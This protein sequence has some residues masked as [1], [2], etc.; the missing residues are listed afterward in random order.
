MGLPLNPLRAVLGVLTLLAAS[1]ALMVAPA[2]ADGPGLPRTYVPRIIDSPNPLPGGSFGWG[3]ASADLT[4]D[5]KLDLLVA[6][7]E[8]GKGN[9]GP[10]QVFIYNGVTGALVD[11]INPPEQNPDSAT[12][13]TLGFVYVETMPDLGSCPGGDGADADRICDAATIGAVDGIPEIVVGAR[14]LRVDV[15]N[16]ADGPEVGDPRLGRGYV[17]DGATRA[18]LKRIDMPLADRRAQFAISG[19]GAAPQFGRTM[20]NP[21][22]LEPCTGLP[23]GENNNFGV[24]ACPTRT[25]A[26]RIGDVNGGGQPDIAITARSQ[27][28][29]TGPPAA[30]AEEYAA[31][32]TQCRAA[33]AGGTCTSGKV[34][35]YAG[36]AIAG[37]NPQTILDTPIYSIQ[38]PRA[39]TGGA[40]FGGNMTRVGDTNGDGR[41]EFVIPARQLDYPLT[42]PDPGAGN[43]GEN[44]GASFLFNGATG[45]LIRIVPSPEPQPRSQFGG[46]FNS[47]RPVG[48]LGST[49][50]P[51]YV[52]AAPFQNAL[53]TDDGKAWVFNGDLTV[54]GGAEQSWNFASLTDPFPQVGSNFGGSLTGVGDLVSGPGAPTN[55]ILIGGF[56]F[57]PF[58]DSSNNLVGDLHFV[59]PGL[60]KTLQTVPHP[61]GTRGDGFGVGITP[62]GDLNG[63]GFLD[64][65]ASAYLTNIG[66][67][68][69]QG[70]A[71]IFTSDNSPLPAPPSEPPAET[72]VTPRVL[73]AG[74]CSN[75]TMGTNR[76]DRLEGTIAGDRI[77]GFR[78]DDAITGFQSE[79]C[80]HGGRGDD[81][82]NGSGDNDRLVG[83][84]GDDRLAGADGRDDLRGG[85]G[86]DRLS[87]G[88]G[89]DFI[90]GGAGNDRISGGQDADRLLGER[91][92]D[93]IS[94]GDGR[95]KVDAGPGNDRIQARNGERDDIVCG[96]GRDVVV[97]DRVDR[98]D[99]GCEQLLLPRRRG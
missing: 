79:D 98:V 21:S 22:G 19:A 86:A 28:E 68:A 91:G 6:Q 57:D 53:S 90:A 76:A 55:E 99:G 8:A 50:T 36:E 52:Q 81:R 41:P 72:P 49:S 59:N 4:G 47:G 70:R 14:N 38:N 89:R 54:G 24:T 9:G 77:F 26:E 97:A 82:L 25:P 40:E 66:P 80:I 63:D 44:V 85:S 65:A 51:D 27:V 88:F 33:A 35:V 31:A 61:E 94:T 34:W 23:P 78:G 32:G 69:G 18:V 7:A 58:T 62:M 74:R 15:E 37:T 20:M 17:F 83:A 95:N 87:G 12:P 42:N 64:F 60:Q 45:A 30:P 11:T 73:V 92:N 13:P 43:P 29:R 84:S 16:S 39:Q 3:I 5:G 48:D 46:G 2:L 67:T 56:G 10:G 96:T 1:V 71:Y 93:R 75:D